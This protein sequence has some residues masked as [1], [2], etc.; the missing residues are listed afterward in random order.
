MLCGECGES[1][2]Q[3]AKFC[4]KCGTEL[5]FKHELASLWSRAVAF[6]LDLLITYVICFGVG[7]ALIIVL[8]G[9]QFDETISGFNYLINVIIFFGY[10]ILLEGR[11]G[12]GQTIGKKALHIKV[13]K[14]EDMDVMGYTQSFV[15]NIL[16]IIDGL[17]C[18]IVGILLIHSSDKNQRLGDSAVHTLVIKEK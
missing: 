7:L 13:L 16:R 10:F 18:Y 6:L 15:R 17:F 9:L 4:K 11:L 3:D 5:D 2:M 8:G 14:E 12:G 1:N